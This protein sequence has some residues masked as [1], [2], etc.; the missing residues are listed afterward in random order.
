VEEKNILLDK[1]Y[2]MLA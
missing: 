1:E 2:G